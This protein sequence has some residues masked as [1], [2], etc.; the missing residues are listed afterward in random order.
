MTLLKAV[1]SLCLLT[2]QAVAGQGG[3]TGW[4]R[5]DNDR[6]HGTLCAQIPYVG[7][8]CQSQAWWYALSQD[9]PPPNKPLSP[10][11]R[12]HY[13]SEACRLSDWPVAR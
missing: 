13:G 1:L 3:Q 4:N 7:T 9:P 2:N 6:Q 5:E 11:C 10:E 8:K 12:E